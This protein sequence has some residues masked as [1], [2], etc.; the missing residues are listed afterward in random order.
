MGPVSLNLDGII[1]VAEGEGGPIVQSTPR[2]EPSWFHEDI[3]PELV[4]Q[5]LRPRHRTW[6]ASMDPEVRDFMHK[7]LMAYGH[8][9]NGR[10]FHFMAHSW[11]ETAY[12]AKD[13]L[14][15]FISS[16]NMRLRLG[17]AA[18][19]SRLYDQLLR[20]ELTDAQREV[21]DRKLKE[22]THA[23]TARQHAPRL[24]AIVQDEVAQLLTPVGDE[25]ALPT[26]S[27]DR[28][29]VV[30]LLRQCGHATNAAGD[31]ES[32]YMAFDCA[33][34]LSHAAADLLSAANMR[35]KLNA[36]SPVAEALYT[37]CLTLPAR[38]LPRPCPPVSHASRPLASCFCAAVDCAHRHT[39]SRERLE[40]LALGDHP[41]RRCRFCPTAS[42]RWLHGSS[43]R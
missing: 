33:Y 12:L 11:F 7:R 38:T 23:K 35:V 32:A 29:H 36:A 40:R 15:A 5:C 28:A 10:G 24:P 41:L 25:P 39:Q 37:H 17:Q 26:A 9:A 43:T 18:L 31:V 42:S 2:Y 4:Q 19:A 21:V 6:T 30:R 22:V 13:D 34:A 16:I 20:G 27:E 8:D 1:L 14:N 3:S